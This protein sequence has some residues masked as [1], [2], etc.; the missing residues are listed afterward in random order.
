MGSR[1]DRIEDDRGR[2]ESRIDVIDQQ[3]DK[4][5]V[6]KKICC[7]N[8]QLGKNERLFHYLNYFYF[9]YVDDHCRSRGSPTVGERTV[10][11]FGSLWAMWR[12]MWHGWKRTARPRACR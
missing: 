10:T 11:K 4:V 7:C 9:N 1:L 3:L 6:Q 8:V 12:T 5:S 2:E